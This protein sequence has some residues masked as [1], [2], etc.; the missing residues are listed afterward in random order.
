MEGKYVLMNGTFV[1]ADDYRI[2]V[3]ESDGFLFAVR[4]RAIRTS[5]PFFNEAL[6]HVQLKLQA[7]NH[8]FPEFTDREGAAMRR[9]LERTLTKNKFF[10]GAVFYLSFWSENGKVCYVIRA[11]KHENADFE[12]NE[13]GSFA[14]TF[15]RL[16]KPACKFYDWSAESDVLWKI[17]RFHLAHSET[18]QYF[19][20]NAEG[21]IVEA[22]ESNI[23]CICKDVVYGCSAESGA[24][25]NL[26]R[27]YLQAVLS[28]MNLKYVET[29]GFTSEILIGADEIM[30]VNAVDGI[31]WVVGFEGK[32]YFNQTIRKINDLFSR[33]WVS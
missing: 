1:A 32:R 15:D 11:T 29:Q 26:S 28:K 4:I 9:Q 18:D 5:F 10:M 3:T 27:N 12:L 23:Y 8:S 6:L 21:S 17:A 19:L 24:S 33:L 7:F 14:E 30:L 2:S 20:I 13:K 25:L 31:R 16:M 22:V